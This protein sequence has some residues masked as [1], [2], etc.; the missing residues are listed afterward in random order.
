MARQNRYRQIAEHIFWAHY[1]PGATSVEFDREEIVTAAEALGVK[2]P[3]N[4]GDLLYSFRSRTEL[5]DSILKT[6][7]SNKEWIID[8]SARS[9]YEFKLA[10][11]SRIVPQ[12]HLIKVKIPDATP[13]IVTRYALNDE[14]ALLAK[15]RYNRLIDIFLGITSYSLQ[16]HLRTTVNKTQIEIDEL[17]VG[18]NRSGTHFVVP[19]QAKAGT[20][21]IT[22]VQ[23]RQDLRYCE[24]K[25]PSLACRAVSA[26]FMEGGVI[27]M[28]ELALE[29]DDL[30]VVNERHYKLVRTSDLSDAEVESYKSTSDSL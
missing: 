20:D 14:Q 18:V 26:Q 27:A 19:V 29:N 9:K 17:Y 13:Q 28:F 6:A 24:A 25:F 10:T 1:K 30:V 5:P 12:S 23:T 7:P 8:I 16:N 22:A 21:Q 11:I 4:L 2:R 15:V 3:D